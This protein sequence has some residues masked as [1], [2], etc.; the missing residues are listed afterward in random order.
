MNL[1]ICLE[2]TM[3]SNELEST[4]KDYHTCKPAVIIKE[5]WVTRLM[6]N[7]HLHNGR[8]AV[9]KISHMSTT[10]MYSKENGAYD[11]F[12]CLSRQSY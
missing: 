3:I 2:C 9:N 11:F 4:T 1:A 8:I 12:F 10:G 7:W 6:E 5:L